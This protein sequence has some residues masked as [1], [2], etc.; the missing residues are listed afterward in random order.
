MFS[1]ASL[2]K[3]RESWERFVQTL[4]EQA[5]DPHDLWLGVVGLGLFLL[6]ILLG[7]RKHKG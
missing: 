7:S 5:N 1:Q 3:I 6:A 4:R 2:Q